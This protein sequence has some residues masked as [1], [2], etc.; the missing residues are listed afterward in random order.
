MRT[1]GFFVVTLLCL[2]ALEAEAKQ[3]RD[4]KVKHAFVLRDE[5]GVCPSTGKR[6]LPCPGY[7]A[8]HAV[9]LYCGG[10]DVPENLVWLTVE[11]HKELHRHTVCRAPR[12]V[13][14]P[15]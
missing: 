13:K 9:P 2:V 15:P 6:A 7:E 3:K 8:H 1:L 4:P 5:Q 14:R 10:K 12:E 11:Q